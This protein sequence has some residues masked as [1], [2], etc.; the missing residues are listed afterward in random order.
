MKPTIALLLVSL[1]LNAEET[2]QTTLPAQASVTVFTQVKTGDN[3]YGCKTCSQNP[4]GHIQSLP[5]VWNAEPCRPYKP[6]TER[7]EITNVI[8]RITLTVEWNG[9]S[10]T[11]AEEYLLSSTTNHYVLATKWEPKP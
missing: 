6:A 1:V 11:Q 3:S 5:A 9:K 7:W 2:I 8:Q 4:F 10:Y